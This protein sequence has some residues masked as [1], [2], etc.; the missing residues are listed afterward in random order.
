MVDMLARM[1]CT[2]LCMQNKIAIRFILDR[3]LT[4]FDEVDYT[5]S[6]ISL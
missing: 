1:N 4:K 3:E 5:L 6:Y 2:L